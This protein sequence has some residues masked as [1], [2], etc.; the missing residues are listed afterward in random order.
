MSEGWISRAMSNV[1]ELE[2]DSDSRVRDR[3]TLMVRS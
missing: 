3:A 1:G 2:C